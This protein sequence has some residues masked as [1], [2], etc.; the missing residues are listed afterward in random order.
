MSMLDEFFREKL[1][2]HSVVPPAGA[3][4]R[5]EAGLAKKNNGFL[6]LRWAAVFL[7][8]ALVLGAVWMK[9]EVASPLVN[10]KPIPKPVEK[11]DPEPIITD[12]AEDK[13]ES[14]N[15]VKERKSRIFKNQPFEQETRRKD[16]VAEIVDFSSILII[17]VAGT[18][19]NG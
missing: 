16:E 18:V 11:K 4:Q 15:V 13:V 17:G 2:D 1:T 12:H 7:L 3:W 10:K 5:V 8:G 14:K 19:G 6:W 9:R